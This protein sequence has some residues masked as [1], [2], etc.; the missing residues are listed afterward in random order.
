MF[1]LDGDAMQCVLAL[2]G[3]TNGTNRGLTRKNNSMLMILS[4]VLELLEKI[5]RTR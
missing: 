3:E 2:N 4:S 1:H 5:Q